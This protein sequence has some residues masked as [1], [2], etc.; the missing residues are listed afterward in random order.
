MECATL[1]EMSESRKYRALEFKAISA[2]LDSMSPILKNL[3]I[4]V[5]SNNIEVMCK[6]FPQSAD[7]THAM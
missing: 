6:T 4:T 7:Q 1:N 3:S 5:K 2:S